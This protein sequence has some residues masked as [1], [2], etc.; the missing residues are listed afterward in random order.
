MKLTQTILALSCLTFPLFASAFFCPNNFNQINVGDSI[1]YVTQQCGKP[2]NTKE[3][4]KKNDNVPQEWSYYIPQTVSTETSNQAQGTLKTSI[5]F[6]EKGNA[7]NISVNGLGVGST[8]ICGTSVQLGDSRDS[9]KS[10]C[11][12]PSFINKQQL[13]TTASPPQETKVT[14]LT[15]GNTKLL[16]ENGKLTESK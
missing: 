1:D 6:D 8:T 11:G 4:T 7:I 5:T 15:F 9:V 12:D 16:F 10:A 3:S 14:E 2:D 13:P